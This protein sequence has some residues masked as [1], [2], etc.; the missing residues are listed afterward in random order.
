MNAITRLISVL[1]P[2]PLEPTSAVVVPGRRAEADTCFSTGTPG[3]Y[4]NLT[5]SN[6]T[7]PS[8][9]AERRARR[10]LV[11]LGRHLQDLADAIEAGE[12]LGDLRADR[13]DLHDRRRHQAGEE[14]VGDEVAERHRARRGSRGRRR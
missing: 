5:S 10:V 2:D 4:S 13:R 7:S 9:V 8:S 11:V 14:D 3:L 6:A 12:R 1:L